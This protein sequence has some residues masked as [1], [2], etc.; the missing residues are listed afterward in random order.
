[1]AQHPAE[2]HSFCY[3]FETATDQIQPVTIT[4]VMVTVAKQVPEIY[5]SVKRKKTS[6]RL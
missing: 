4:K 3:S 5:A 6:A 1:V 2:S